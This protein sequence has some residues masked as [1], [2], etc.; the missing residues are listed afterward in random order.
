MLEFYVIFERKK[1]F[2]SDFFWGG[3]NAP[4]PLVSYAYAKMLTSKPTNQPTN[5]HH[6]SQYLLAG[7]KCY[8]GMIIAPGLIRPDPTRLD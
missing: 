4:C 3:A 7:V 5:K 1:Y 6:G 8:D 2:F